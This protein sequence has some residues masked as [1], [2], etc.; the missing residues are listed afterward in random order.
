MVNSRVALSLQHQA[1]SRTVWLVNALAWVRVAGHGCRF[2]TVSQCAELVYFG[3]Y[4]EVENFC[5]EEQ[6]VRKAGADGKNV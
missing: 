1:T 3:T 5:L 2:G 6:E 4:S